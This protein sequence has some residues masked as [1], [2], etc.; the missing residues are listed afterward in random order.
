MLIIMAL[1]KASPKTQY[2]KGKNCE[3]KSILLVNRQQD[4]M[5]QLSGTDR[6]KPQWSKE[7]GSVVVLA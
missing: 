5:T 4:L 7:K 6:K 1:G 3:L 2:P